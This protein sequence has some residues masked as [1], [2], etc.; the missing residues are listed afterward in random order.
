MRGVL[1]TPRPK[2]VQLPLQVLEGSGALPDR[3]EADVCVVG[4]GYA[5]LTA[6]R[7]MHQAGR[8]VVVL[9]ARD[10]I[11]GRIWTQHLDDGSAVDR[12]ASGSWLAPVS[13]P[14]RGC[15]CTDLAE[16]S[17]RVR[18][19]VPITTA[20]MSRKSPATTRIGKTPSTSRLLSTRPGVLSPGPATHICERPSRVWSQA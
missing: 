7:R 18:T 1:S 8:S 5:G 16:R 15:C 9:E 14:G 2:F 3:L 17:R 6:A 13:D 12:L 10:R 20:M 4:A 19:T 11:G